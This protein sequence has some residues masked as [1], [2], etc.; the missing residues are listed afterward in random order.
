MVVYALAVLV[1]LLVVGSVVVAPLRSGARDEQREDER[2]ADLEAA[3]EAKY[4][5]IRDLRLDHQMGKVSDQDFAVADAELSAD[6]VAIL[7]R[8]DRLDPSV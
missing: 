8:L 5:E 6:A 1:L 4:A 2:R 3:R 7:R